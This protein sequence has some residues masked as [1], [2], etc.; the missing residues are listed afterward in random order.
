[1]SHSGERSTLEAIDLSA[2]PVAITHANPH[3]WHPVTRNKSDDVLRA[4]AKSGGMLGFSLYTHHLKGGAACELADF[5]AMVARAA[6][7]M[8]VDHIGIGSDLTQDQPDSV[9]AWMR[10][11]RW[12]KES[13]EASFPPPP[14]WFR[15]N[16]GFANLRTGLSAAGFSTGDCAKILGGN[17]LRFFAES[18]GPR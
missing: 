13:G 8:G 9:V 3:A 1:M 16:S 11:G 5:C 18:F 7:L 10:S 14:P 2:R 4:L 17:W 12:T 6:D 15:D